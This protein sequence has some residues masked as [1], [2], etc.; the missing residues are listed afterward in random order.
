M[1]SDYP[2]T[3]GAH[4]KTLRASLWLVLVISAVANS[5]ATF[6]TAGTSVHVGLAA[7]TG[8]CIAGLVALVVR[9]RR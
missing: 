7:V 2:T 5:V 9:S 8:A 4:H 3:A 6:A 1:K